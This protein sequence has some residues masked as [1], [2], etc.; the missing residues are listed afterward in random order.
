MRAFDLAPISTIHGFC[1]RVLHHNAFE[2][3][4]PLTSELMIDETPMVDQVV[5][6]FWAHELYGADPRFITHLQQA[7]AVPSRLLRLARLVA[8]RPE[9]TLRP[10]PP[11]SPDDLDPSDYV[12]CYREVRAIWQRDRSEITELLLATRVLHKSQY[13]TE[14]MPGWFAA[15]DA[16]LI[17]PDPGPLFSFGGLARFSADALL[18]RTAAADKRKGL[19]PRHAFFDACAELERARA[20][21]AANYD[22]RLLAFKGELVRYVRRELPKRK[23]AAGLQSFDDLLLQLDVALRSKGGKN[24]AEHI[25][26]R[27]KAALIDEFQDTDPV[28]YRI[29]RT[30]FGAKDRSLLLIGDPKQAIYGFRGADVFAYLEAARLAGK[31]RI[32]MRH[33]WRSDPALLAAVQRLFEVQRPFLLADIELPEVLPRPGARARLH[34]G[35]AAMPAMTVAFLSREHAELKGR[36]LLKEWAE[37]EIPERIASEIAELLASGATIDDGDGPRPVHAGDIA[38]LTRKN[39]QALQVQLA[40]RKR[41]LPSVVYG[42][43]TV[44]EG[45]E[46]AELSRVLASAAEPSH[47]GMLK[48]ALATELVGIRADTLAQLGDDDATWEHWVEC[49]RRLHELWT[50]RGF[51]QA[52]RALLQ[53]TRAQAR[54]LALQG[55]ERRMTNL[56]HLAELLHAEASEAHLGPA[57]LLRW[58]DEQR[59]LRNPMVDAFKLRLERDDRAVQ[60]I[61]IHR[62][63]GLEYPIVY[64]PY[65]W[66]GEDVRSDEKEDLLYHDPDDGLATVLDLRRG[67]DPHKKGAIDHARREHDAESL[68]LLYVAVTRARHRCVLVWAASSRANTSALGYLLWSPRPGEPELARERIVRR[69][70]DA[71]DAAMITQLSV[72]G[73]GVWT[74]APLLRV[75]SP[76]PSTADKRAAAPP[77]VH[78]RPRASI[79]RLWRTA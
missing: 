19:T 33:N 7:K 73:E 75:S 57:G 27:H 72:R 47:R 64:V 31:R 22:Q 54:L 74:V 26:R 36:H 78:R 79:D 76:L 49:F 69:I 44:F 4:V 6:D 5:R 62:S 18:Q 34:Q 61:T 40:L 10:E 37:L 28:Q 66:D 65:A 68:R 20:P 2:T 39:A 51:I 9:L 59:R 30:L 3:G 25:R 21:L 52:F 46:A 24:L 12:A 48:A 23:R 16:F 55:G 8:A 41:G 70:H 58:F 17:T 42:D 67:D 1:Q 14:E 11:R 56:L 53:L 60:L 43:S 35:G 63:K 29:F 15:L 13:P 77:L 71:D 45:R 50:T 38:V 32:T